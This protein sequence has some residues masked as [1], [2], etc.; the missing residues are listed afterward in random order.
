[1]A[2]RDPRK[3]ARNK[4]VAEMQAE[5]R[6]LQPQVFKETKYKNEASLNARIGHKAD[7]FIDLKN[8]VI[9]SP[10]HYVEFWRAGFDAHRTGSK[11]WKNTFDILFDE[12]KAS[13][14]FQRYLDLFL[15]RSYLKHYDELSK[16]RPTASDAE[17]WLGQ[18]HAEYGLLIAPRF[19]NGDWENDK[20]EIR[21]FRPAYWTVGHALESGFV[22]PGKKTGH[23]TFKN[24]EQYLVF[25]E[26]TLVRSTASKYQKDVAARYCDYVRNKAVDP[27]KVPLLLPELRYEGRTGPHKYRLDFCIID[28][29]TLDKIGIELSPWSTHGLL[30]GIK[31]KTQKQVNAVAL[32][33]FEKEMKKLK[34]FFQQRGIYTLIYTD[35]D[36]ANMKKVFSDIEDKLQPGKPAQQFSFALSKDYFK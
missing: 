11:H 19:R 15:H 24:V 36:L 35:S 18:S 4:R 27:R 1:M 17:V 2:K 6:A 23:V 16:K 30:T 29:G 5:L 31:A 7:V 32:G 3:T 26:H 25:F 21:H 10:Q 28:P 8:E 20:S 22:V 13:P 34:S 33:N 14:A 12:V 9:L